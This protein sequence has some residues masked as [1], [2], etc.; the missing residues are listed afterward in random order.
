MS[1]HFLSYGHG[2]LCWDFLPCV[3]EGG[4]C[5]LIFNWVHEQTFGVF[6]QFGVGEDSKFLKDWV[7]VG[8]IFVACY[9]PY[10]FF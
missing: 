9:Y 4:W 2:Q 1:Y 7:S 10:C 5:I 3:I 8:V 6:S